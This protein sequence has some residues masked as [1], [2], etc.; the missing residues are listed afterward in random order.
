MGSHRQD[1]LRGIPGWHREMD[2]RQLAAV[3]VGDMVMV[4]HVS[5]AGISTRAPLSESA[6]RAMEIAAL[7]CAFTGGVIPSWWMAKAD[8]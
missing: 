1:T 6:A 5:A 4:C 7:A 8:G 3:W 2:G